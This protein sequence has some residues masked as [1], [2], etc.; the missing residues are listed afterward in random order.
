[1]RIRS[2]LAVCA[3]LLAAPAAA[4]D[5]IVIIEGGTRSGYGKQGIIDFAK[6]YELNPRDLTL[7]VL[8]H[9]FVFDIN[10]A[11]CGAGCTSLRFISAELGIDRT[12]TGAN[13]AEVSAAFKDFIKSED[14]LKRFIRLINSGAGAQ[15]S[16]SPVGSIGSAVRM[17]FQDLMFN[18]I[19]T[20]EQKNGQPAGR[21]PAFSGGFAQF[22]SDGFNGNIVSVTPGFQLDFGGKRDKHLKFSFPLTQIDFEGLKTYRAG[23]A[24][25]YLYPIYFDNNITLTAGPGL[26]YLG[27]FSVDLP[28]YSGLLGGALSTSLQKDW[29]QFFTTGAVYYGKFANAGGIDTDISANIYGWGTQTGYRFKKRWV[30]ALHLVGLHERVAG[31]EKVTYHTVSTSLSYK[32]LNKFNLTFSVSKLVGLPKQ[33]FVDVG[34]GTAWFF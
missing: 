27:T 29:E 4:R 31:F 6:D 28:N 10:A 32:I 33:R 26:S 12:F 34:M 11:G 17:G 23:L 20:T 5:P 7:E 19:K 1:M 8:G 30:T 14:F 15:I 9:P 22:S 18:G 3:L 16:G 21:D 24:M 25:Q 2:F 13:T